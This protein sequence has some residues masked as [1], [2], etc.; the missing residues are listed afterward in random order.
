M[1][2]ERD[3]ERAIINRRHG[4]ISELGMGH[5]IADSEYRLFRLLECKAC[6]WKPS[7]PSLTEGPDE[8]FS[9]LTLGFFDRR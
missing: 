1:I 5:R 4:S 9:E 7:L 6:L 3:S 8:A 2:D